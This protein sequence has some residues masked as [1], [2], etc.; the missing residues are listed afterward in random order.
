MWSRREGVIAG[1]AAA[2][3]HGTRW[4]DRDAPVELIYRN[5]RCPAGVV[6]R[7]ELLLEGEV[8]ASGALSVTTPARTGFD[9]GR[10]STL[11]RAVA[12]LDALMRA[13]GVG[14]D[15]IAAL[16]RRHHHARGLRQLEK[17]LSLADRGAQSPKESWLRLVLI[18]GGLPRPQTQ[19]PVFDEQGYPIAYLDL[20]WPDV[21]VAVEYDGD[22]HR[23]DRNQYV[24]DIRRRERLEQMGWI[25][26]TVVAEDRPA[27]IIKRV[28]RAL[29]RSSVR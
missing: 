9:L 19:I 27:D 3:L 11:T 16:A 5:P 20:G 28:L 10:R 14:C 24:K 26:I 21:K 2:F 18:R 6:V 4:V 12:D 15:D 25:I 17:V 29:A 8:T 22:H 13:T 7:R 1:S 23:A